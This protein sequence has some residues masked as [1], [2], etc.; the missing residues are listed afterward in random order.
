MLF[1]IFGNMFMSSSHSSS[2]SVF[3]THVHLPTD[4]VFDALSVM[5]DFFGSIML[6]LLPVVALIEWLLACMT[7]FCPCER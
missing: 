1:G 6:L 5:T 2:H 3:N 4:S 7:M